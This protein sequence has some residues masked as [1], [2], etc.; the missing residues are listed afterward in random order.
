M[1]FAGMS[2]CGLKHDGPNSAA[3]ATLDNIIDQLKQ[4]AGAPS[5]N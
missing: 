4:L 5:R 2:S 3:I 1:Q